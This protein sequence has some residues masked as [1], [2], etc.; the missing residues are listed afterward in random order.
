[1]K[2][3][4]RVLVGLASVVLIVTLFSVLGQAQEKIY[5]PVLSRGSSINS[6][7]Q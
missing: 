6:G 7:R 5:I 1:M 3:T 4:K 2:N